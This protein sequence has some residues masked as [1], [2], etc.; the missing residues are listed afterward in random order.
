MGQTDFQARL[1]RIGANAEVSAA[2]SAHLPPTQS[3][4]PQ[5]QK[6]N[7][8]LLLLAALLIS[9]TVQ[10]FR[11]LEDNFA[12]IRSGEVSLMLA[13][14]VGLATVVGLFVCYKLVSRAVPAHSAKPRPFDTG[15]AASSIAKTISSLIGLLFGVVA[16]Y[17]RHLANAAAYLDS[18]KT[19]TLN[20]VAG[21]AGGSL[22]LVSL[23][24]AAIG[25]HRRRFALGRVLVYF[26]AGFILTLTALRM[27]GLSPED[28]MRFAG[29]AP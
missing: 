23:T 2:P 8:K 25:L 7:H 5:R 26:L 27:S 11:F 22:F 10:G 1:A 20:S 14:S 4:H 21:L 12:A 15:P 19:E 24:L 18:D 29:Q 28:V 13:G 6:P 3:A 9:I 16:A 17:S